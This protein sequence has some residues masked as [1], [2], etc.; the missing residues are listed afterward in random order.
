VLLP[1]VCGV[2]SA[3]PKCNDTHSSLI[4]SHNRS[5]GYIGSLWLQTHCVRIRTVLALKYCSGVSHAADSPEVCQM[6]M[7]NNHQDG[8]LLGRSDAWPTMCLHTA[9][10]RPEP[11]FRASF[12]PSSSRHKVGSRSVHDLAMLGEILSQVVRLIGSRDLRP[13]TDRWALQSLDSRRPR[14]PNADWEVQ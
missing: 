13:S 6:L 3:D 5:L 1:R 9:G 4:K 8:S 12:V 2:L 7:S 11:I 10:P 14:S